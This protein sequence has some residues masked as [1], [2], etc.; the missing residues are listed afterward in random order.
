MPTVGAV[1]IRYVY[2]IHAL[3]RAFHLNKNVVYGVIL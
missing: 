1:G 3:L 2:H